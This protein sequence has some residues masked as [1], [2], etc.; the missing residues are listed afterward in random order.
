MRRKDREI[1]ERNRIREIILSCHCCRLGFCDGG[2]VYIIPLNFGYEEKDGKRIFYFHGAREGR[3]I[4]LIAQTQHA[5]FE[6]DTGYALIEAGTACQHSARYQSVVGTGR[7]AIIGEP[8][9]K[10]AALQTI[11]LHYTGKNDWDFPDAALGSVCV[12]K[13]EVE[14]LSCKEH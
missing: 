9:E 8:E 10:R 12:F 3:K 4:G 6:L 5:G 14:K 7:V 1:S 11:M 13:L 2:E